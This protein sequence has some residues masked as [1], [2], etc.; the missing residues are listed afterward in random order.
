VPAH[1]L[2]TRNLSTYTEVISHIWDIQRRLYAIL[3]LPTP[4]SVNARRTFACC[5]PPTTTNVDNELYAHFCSPPQIVLVQGTI[6]PGSVPR[7]S[8]SPSV[9][10][11]TASASTSSSLR[12]TK[13]W[14]EGLAPESVEDVLFLPWALHS[15]LEEAIEQDDAPAF[16][17][18]AFMALSALMYETAHWLSE[19]WAFS[20]SLFFFV[21]FFGRRE[22][23]GCRVVKVGKGEGLELIG[24]WF[25][26]SLCRVNGHRP[27]PSLRSVTVGLSVSAKEALVATRKQDDTGMRVVALLLGVEVEHL[28][29]ADG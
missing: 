7:A 16:G 23:K 12:G 24:S 9:Y 5:L 14:T 3:Q 25:V 19:R 11:S 27:Q 26:V 10:S 4:E 29:F 8:N 6:D 2:V 18:A 22:E 28:S 15:A 21:F 1:V 17:E 20:F 13:T